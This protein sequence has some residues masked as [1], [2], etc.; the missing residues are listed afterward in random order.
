MRRVA[1][2]LALAVLAIVPFSLVGSATVA[3]AARLRAQLA[4]VSNQVNAGIRPTIKYAS[5]GTPAGSRL[6][7]Q[8][9]FG[10]ANVWKTV[11]KLNGLEGRALTVGVPQGRYHYRVAVYTNGRF[12]TSSSVRTLYSYSSVSLATLC[13]APNV[14]VGGSGCAPGTMQ[15]G[16]HVFSYEIIGDY[17]GDEPPNYATLIVFPNNRC[18]TLSLTFG[19]DS[20]NS[21]TGEVAYVQILQRT[22]DPQ[23][24]SAPQGRLGSL[25]AR[26]DRGPWYL[27]NSTTDGDLVYYNGSASCWSADGE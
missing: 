2:Y 26:L 9:Q 7:L 12:I 14:T 23:H 17:L 25:V 27:Q 5:T 6:Y 20:N 10:L 3:S 8:R 24:A 15:V 19:L 16:S 21:Q 11:E 18:R 4:F 13:N 1:F 22:L